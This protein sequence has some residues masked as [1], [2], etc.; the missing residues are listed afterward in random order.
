MPSIVF[1]IGSRPALTAHDADALARFL[2]LDCTDAVS[3]LATKIR[4]CTR[5]GVDVELVNGDIEAL[6][7]LFR[8]APDLLEP[9]FGLADLHDEVAA[10]S[11]P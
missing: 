9:E 10:V 2:D 4:N 8:N 5:T 11:A 1:A 6:A 7:D 3:P